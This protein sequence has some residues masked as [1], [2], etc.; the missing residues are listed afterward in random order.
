MLT[1]SNSCLRSLNKENLP[2]KLKRLKLLWRKLARESPPDLWNQK[3]A[4]PERE[5]EPKRQPRERRWLRKLDKLKAESW[6][7]RERLPQ[8]KRLEDQRLL[9][10]RRLE[11]RIW[12][13]W[14]QLL[15]RRRTLEATEL[16][17][18]P[19]KE[20]LLRS[21]KRKEELPARERCTRSSL[22]TK[23]ITMK[24]LMINTEM[25]S[26]MST[27]LLQE[28]KEAAEDN[29]QALPKENQARRINQLARNLRWEDDLR[30]ERARPPKK[31]KRRTRRRVKSEAYFPY[32]N[33]IWMIRLLEHKI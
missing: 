25:A 9:R 31:S 20:A 29:Q 28:W 11:R 19:R 15:T 17:K 33:Y 6:P 14:K 8:V 16:L 26:K 18:D 10:K 13:K 22:K 2:R 30:W 5:L 32:N 1:I 4:R 24:L 27:I 23:M 3:E 21:N 12:T 7:R